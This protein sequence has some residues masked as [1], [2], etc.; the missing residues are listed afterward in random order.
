MAKKKA[1]RKVKK[2]KKRPKKKKVVRGKKKAKVKAKAKGEKVI[3]VVDHFFGKISVAAFKLKAPL[4]VGDMIHI[5]GH[6]TDFIQKV[7]SIQIEHESVP[8][9]GKGAEVGIKVKGKVRAGDTVYF[10]TGEKEISAQPAAVQKP[11]FPV[12]AF[13]P[14]SPQPPTG[15]RPITPPSASRSPEKKNPYGNTRFLKF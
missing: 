5:K 6:T 15:E 7:D 2:A 1:K 13:K 4:R 9:A 3:A 10:A 8:K 14:P 12:A 11:M